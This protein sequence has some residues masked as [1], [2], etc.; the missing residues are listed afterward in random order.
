M[1]YETF[2]RAADILKTSDF[3]TWDFARKIDVNIELRGMDGLCGGPCLY[4]LNINTHTS[5][6]AQGLT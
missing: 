3:S 6:N 4:E 5:V 2:S 1:L